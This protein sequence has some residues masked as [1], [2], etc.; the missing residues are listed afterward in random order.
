M[1][2]SFN[3]QRDYITL[4]NHCEKILSPH[5]KILFSNNFRTFKFAVESFKDKFKIEDISKKTIPQ[6]FRNEKI[7][8]A[9]LLSR[10]S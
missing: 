2:D 3:V 8:S 9:W 5:G 10:I 7:H 6:D 4:I 1:L